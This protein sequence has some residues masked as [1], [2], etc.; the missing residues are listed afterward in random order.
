LTLLLIYLNNV[1]KEQALDLGIKELIFSQK[2]GETSFNLDIEE[3]KN[4]M[5]ALYEGF[6][7][8]VTDESESVVNIYNRYNDIQELFPDSL[9]RA[10]T[11]LTRSLVI[12]TPTLHSSVSTS[13]SPYA[14]TNNVPLTPVISSLAN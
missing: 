5:K 8:D 7:I 4:C 1:A 2:Y 9:Q 14:D 10:S 3:R 6:M 12:V 13:S 11:A